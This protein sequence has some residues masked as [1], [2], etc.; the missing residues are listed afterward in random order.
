MRHAVSSQRLSRPG[1]HRQAL[2]QGL[3]KS[4]IVHGQICTTLARAKVAQRLADR[5][6]TFGKEGSIHA[7]RQAYRV[8]QSETLVK[9]LFGDIAPRFVDANGGYTR[10]M[11]LDRRHGDG[12]QQALLAFSRLPAVQPAVPEGPKPAQ[13]PKPAPATPGRPRPEKPEAAEKPKGLFEGLR[14]LWTRKKKG[15][16]A[17]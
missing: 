14:T 3:V 2:V 8:L 12:A 5:L 16:A 6:V 9:R 1:D 10:V 4:L 15:S 13:A 7:R 11:R 17:S